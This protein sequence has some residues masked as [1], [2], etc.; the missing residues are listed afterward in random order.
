MLKQGISV[1]SQLMMLQRGVREDTAVSSTTSLS[2]K[3]NMV[4]VF[5]FVYFV[6]F[7]CLGKRPL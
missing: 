5:C 2:E 6:L 1:Y 4:W 3:T 7:F